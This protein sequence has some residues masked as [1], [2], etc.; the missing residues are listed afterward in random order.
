MCGTTYIPRLTFIHGGGRPRTAGSLRSGGSRRH[1]WIDYDLPMVAKKSRPRR[2]AE[3]TR[4]VLVN[5][6][7]LQ[8]ELVGMD[9]GV[10]HVTLESACALT[11]VPRSS[12]HAAWAIDDDYAPQALF[13]RTVLRQWL[14]I[15]EGTTF[16]GAAEK[17]LA[18]AFEKHGDGLTRNEIIRIS[19]Q[20]ALEEGLSPDDDGQ[21]SGLLSTDMAIKHTLASQPSESRDPEIAEWVRDAETKNRAQRI[22][23]SYRPL[24]E[25][26][27]MRPRAE[28]GDAAFAH[29]A[30][31]IASLT[32][33]LTMRELVLPELE[34]AAQSIRPLDPSGI[35]ATLLGVCVEALVEK[36][37]EPAAAQT[38]N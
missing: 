26:L 35:P 29:L 10:D 31:A 38:D 12:S 34:V 14:A 33:G 21:G 22:E 9:F 15:R 30:L 6:G 1:L 37:F 8:L 18:R 17:A 36:F 16:A 24:G 27:G 3:E 2:S 23:D 5:E 28:Y 25:L 20:A 32:E 7:L 19:I 13:Q 11:N 4:R